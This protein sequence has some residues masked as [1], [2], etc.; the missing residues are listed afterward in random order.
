MASGGID[1]LFARVGKIAEDLQRAGGKDGA[2]GAN[3][4]LSL[5]DAE[6]REQQRHGKHSPNNFEKA[7]ARSAFGNQIAYLHNE[8]NFDVARPIGGLAVVTRISFIPIYPPKYADD[9]GRPEGLSKVV[10]EPVSRQ[11]FNRLK[12][13][14]SQAAHALEN[15]DN[16]TF[17]GAKDDIIKRVG[18]FLSYDQPIITTM[19]SI[20]RMRDAI[21]QEL[22][23][24]SDP[25]VRAVAE[26]ANAWN[27]QV[28]K[29]V[30]DQG[31]SSRLSMRREYML[32]TSACRTS[33]LHFAWSRHQ[34]HYQTLTFVEHTDPAR[35]HP[36]TGFGAEDCATV[37]TLCKIAS[38]FPRQDTPNVAIDRTAL[39]SLPGGWA[40]FLFGRYLQGANYLLVPVEWLFDPVHLKRCA[41]EPPPAPMTRQEPWHALCDRVRREF[42][43]SSP[44]GDGQ[45]LTMQAFRDLWFAARENPARRRS[46]AELAIRLL[47]PL[48]SFAFANPR[49]PRFEFVM[50][51]AAEGAAIILSDARNFGRASERHLMSA[52]II[53]DLGMNDFERG[54]L[55]KNLTEF[56]TQRFVTLAPMGAFRFLGGALDVLSE[57]LSKAINAWLHDDE[58]SD[59]ADDDPTLSWWKRW[60]RRG[61]KAKAEVEKR[62]AS[63]RRDDD[64]ISQLQELTINLTMLNS[65]VNGG[66]VLQGAAVEASHERVS[67]QVEQ[68]GHYALP[69]FMSFKDF[70]DRRFFRNV[71][72]IT[73]I[74]RRYESLRGRVAELSA[75]VEAKLQIAL[76]KNQAQQS[77]DQSDLLGK[78]DRLTWFGI[79]YYAGQ[80]LA[81]ASAGAIAYWL[82]MAPQP[83][84]G[85]KMHGPEDFKYYFYPMLLVLGFLAGYKVMF[86]LAGELRRSV[87]VK[88]LVKVVLNVARLILLVA[89]G[90][91]AVWLI[92]QIG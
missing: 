27:A 39:D 21:R 28:R 12:A 77:K 45:D 42:G 55:I 61:R 26:N 50:C 31:L 41:D 56:S 4:T 37:P 48:I 87:L 73:K 15:Y 86:D 36:E 80:I 72:S 17:F 8:F 22:K 53:I 88:G 44:E 52:S 34:G 18:R 35:Y 75:L 81:Y 70:L 57:D 3:H 91:F 59:E 16:E 66:I 2:E 25:A 67:A 82:L 69:G 65:L 1:A 63:Q 46:A 24:S 51:G 89:I 40:D 62:E 74:A 5:I 60:R 14:R 20:D 71:R 54:R 64:F 85:A 92:P 9:K 32:R 43:V 29:D 10:P 47:R 38:A 84:E 58:R 19:R 6:A 76:D 23:N 13:L 30:L 78:V 49:D 68:I 33:Q 83:Q 11:L 79:V 90:A 7:A